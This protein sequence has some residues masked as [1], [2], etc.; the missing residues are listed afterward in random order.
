MR[1][2][3]DCI[4]I[5]DDSPSDNFLHERMILRMGFAK[6]VVIMRTGHGAIDHLTNYDKK[7]CLPPQLILL[8]VEMPGM[9]GW[10]FLEAYDKLH[11]SD[12]SADVIM[13]VASNEAPE[14]ETIKANSAIKDY[15]VKPMDEEGLQGLMQMHYP[16]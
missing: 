16:H 2:K 11:E 8:D 6:H 4:M 13:M 7:R 1:G 3:L 15:V 5:V 9:N 14:V 10:E 12:K